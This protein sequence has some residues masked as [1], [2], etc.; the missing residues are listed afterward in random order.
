MRTRPL[1]FGMASML[2]VKQMAREVC[3]ILV[4][5]QDE[6]GNIVQDV[7]GAF[8]LENNKLTCQP[9]S[10]RGLMDTPAFVKGQKVYAQDQPALWFRYLPQTFTG[11]YLCARMV[12]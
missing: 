10:L 1:A 3:E 4:T 8:V 9:A 2:E 11:T 5:K 12:T 6:S 7:E